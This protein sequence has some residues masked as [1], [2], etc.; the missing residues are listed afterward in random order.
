MY[1]TNSPIYSPFCTIKDFETKWK[2]G[3]LPGWTGEKAGGALTKF[4]PATADLD[5]SAFKSIEDLIAIGGDRLKAALIARGLKC[6]G[7][8]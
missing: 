1:I 7:Y 6:G 8:C 3:K 5:L 2:E 4:T